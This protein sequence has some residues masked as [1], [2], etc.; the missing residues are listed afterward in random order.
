M[1]IAFCICVNCGE[2]L[3]EEGDSDFC[4]D[5]CKAEFEDWSANVEKDPDHDHADDE[6]R[7][8]QGE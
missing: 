7:E 4:S 6:K 5:K 8:A 3:P 1:T 2:P